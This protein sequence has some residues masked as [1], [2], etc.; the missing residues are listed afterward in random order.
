MENN[1]V[2]HVELDKLECRNTHQ[3]Q[4]RW[5]LRFLDLC[6]YFAN[7]GSKDPSTQCGSVIVRDINK[8]V[9]LGYNGYPAGVKDD[10]SLHH[11]DTKYAK[12][13]HA[14]KNA[15]LFA[16]RDVSGMTLYVWPLPPCSQCASYII[17]SGIKRVVSVI[18]SDEER[19]ARWME[20]N[21]IAFDMMAQAG[22]ELQLYSEGDV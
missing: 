7:K 8:F 15:I 9:S 1:K 22:I 4:K 18:P 12:V 17:Q 11:R 16:Q 3:R 2:V 13:I 6:R 5:D 20:S 14:E 19:K 10:E 21:T